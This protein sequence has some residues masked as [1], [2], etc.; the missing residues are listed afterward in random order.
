MFSQDE[1]DQARAVPIAERHG[2]GLKRSGRELIGP[3]PVCGG[4]D[5]F[6]I[7]TKTN[8]WHCRGCEAGG[9]AIASEMHFNGYSFVEAVRALIGKDA[10]TPN[11]RQPTPAEIAAR[12]ARETKRRREEAQEAARNASSAA[13]IIA[14]L[15]PVAGTPGE[16]YLRDVRKI[17]V[18]RPAI[19]R[20]LEGV[21]ALGWCERTCFWQPDP[22]KPLHEFHGQWLGAII[23]ILTD[24]VTGERTGG[25]TRTYSCEGRK[26]C[27][28]MS[29][30]GVGR[31]GIIRLTPD[32]EVATGL[33]L[34]EAIET[35]LSAMIMGFIPMWAAGST[36]TM[37]DF[38]V[39]PGIEFLTLIA[40]HDGPGLKAA[41]QTRQRWADAGRE[42]MMKIPKQ[43]GEDAN[44][45][46]KRRARA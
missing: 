32:D 22:N 6:S 4:V 2:A 46:L 19:R 35:S 10:G 38:P 14:R 29:L 8:L 15:Q 13:K 42:T 7:N 44:D 11:R 24:P 33:H 37:A 17:D 45:I 40:D 21:E 16:T 20:V 25:I 30:G 9:D 36:T 23:G 1:L 26:L 12:E 28:A 39:I 27:R 41:R 3:C 18:S 5:R 31:K 34:G 43:P